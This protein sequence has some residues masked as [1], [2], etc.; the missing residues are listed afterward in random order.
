[1]ALFAAGCESVSIEQIENITERC[2]LSLMWRQIATIHVCHLMATRQNG[3][4]ATAS[5]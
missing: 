3:R 5:P 1:M 2:A 4:W